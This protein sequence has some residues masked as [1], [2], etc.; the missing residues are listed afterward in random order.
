MSYRL[1]HAECCP[2]LQLFLWSTF[3]PS[4]PEDLAL[5]AE[6]RGQVQEQ[7]ARAQAAEVALYSL[8]KEVGSA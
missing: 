3:R 8:R 4:R 1:Q 6:V 7:E 2:C 5:L